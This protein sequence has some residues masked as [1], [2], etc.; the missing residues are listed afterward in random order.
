MKGIFA[1]HPQGAPLHLSLIVSG[2]TN[3]IAISSVMMACRLT[4]LAAQQH[5]FSLAGVLGQYFPLI[6]D[7]AM[8]SS[9][10]KPGIP[11]RLLD[12]QSPGN[13]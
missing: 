10:E 12:E 8:L 6:D 3:T 5:T 2:Y 4:S 11:R 7:L 9:S 1:W 13:R